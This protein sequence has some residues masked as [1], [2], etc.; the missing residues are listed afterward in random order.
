M[1]NERGW[2]TPDKEFSFTVGQWRGTST[3]PRSN[4]TLRKSNNRY[5]DVTIYVKDADE[6]DA[7]IHI[8]TEW[9]AGLSDG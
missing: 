5:D 7:I 6:A 1:D 2:Y 8:L 4:L 9:K 3:S